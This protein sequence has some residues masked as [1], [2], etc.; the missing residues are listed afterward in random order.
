MSS[1]K[2]LLKLLFI[3]DDE[4]FFSVLKPRVQKEGFFVL[5]AKDGEEGIQK[6][7]IE[8][9]DLIVVDIVMPKF[10]GFEV[11]KRLKEGALTRDLK[12]I[13]LSNYGETSLIYDKEFLE[14][15][16]I[17]KYLIKSDHTPTQ[18]AKEIKSVV[19]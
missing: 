10:N 13:I 2:L 16:G 5:W 6:A 1:E 11:I 12:F 15:L 18:I 14:T 19:S 8:L 3:E 17:K 4:G 9:P 7:R